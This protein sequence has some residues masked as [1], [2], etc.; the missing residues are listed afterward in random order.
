MQTFCC[1]TLPGLQA[2]HTTVLYLQPQ[3]LAGVLLRGLGNGSALQVTG[4]L[5]GSIRDTSNAMR[6]TSRIYIYVTPQLLAWPWMALQLFDVDGKLNGKVCRHLLPLAAAE[7]FQHGPHDMACNSTQLDTDAS[8]M[9]ML[10]LRSQLS[11]ITCQQSK[12]LG[13]ICKQLR[14]GCTVAGCFQS[15]AC[16]IKGQE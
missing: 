5:P 11:S 14:T 16:R 10:L 15:V 2:R 9:Q 8:D 1:C 6:Y 3:G 13:N 12:T 7:N 4:V